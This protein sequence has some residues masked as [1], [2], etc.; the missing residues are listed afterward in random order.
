MAKTKEWG[1][2]IPRAKV[3]PKKE[4]RNRWDKISTGPKKGGVSGVQGGRRKGSEKAKT[5]LFL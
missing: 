2:R 1:N 3:Y 5:K 4:T